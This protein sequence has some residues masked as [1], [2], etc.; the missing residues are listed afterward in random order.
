MSKSTHTKH[1]HDD[2][3]SD[4]QDEFELN[5]DDSSI[6]LTESLSHIADVYPEIDLSETDTNNNTV[7][8]S[9][10]I[11]RT[12]NYSDDSSIGLSCISDIKSAGSD[13][14]EMSYP[15]NTPSFWSDDNNNLD[16]DVLEKFPPTNYLVAYKVIG[17]DRVH[18]GP[19]D[20]IPCSTE[21]VLVANGDAHIENELEAQTVTTVNLS[22]ENATVG[23]LVV[24]GAT[25]I[26][27]YGLYLSGENGSTGIEHVILPE[28]NVDVVYANPINGVVNIYL[29]TGSDNIFPDNKVITIK[30]VTLEFGPASSY[31]INIHVRNNEEEVPVRIEHYSNGL[32][33]RNNAR[34]I[35]DTSGGAV[36]FRFAHLSIPGSAPTWVIENQFHGNSRLLGRSGVEFRGA[37]DYTKGKIIN[38]K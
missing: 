28:D 30:D 26:P 36:T 6:G 13:D 12:E 5:S 4:F 32:R 27:K 23:D 14:N 34:Y 20:D 38:L 19:L 15:S 3:V 29:G 8:E 10:N 24:S 33:S 11:D 7:L 16:S 25:F 31:N 35:L 1:I 37:D 18:A 21:T 9:V 2:T 22:A 17:L